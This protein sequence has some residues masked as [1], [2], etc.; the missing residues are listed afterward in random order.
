MHK[1]K[2]SQESAR[3]CGPP[4]EKLPKEQ[5][6]NEM[7]IEDNEVELEDTGW[8]KNGKE[9]ELFQKMHSQGQETCDLNIATR[10]TGSMTNNGEDQSADTGRQQDVLSEER[11]GENRTQPEEVSIEQ[12]DILDQRVKT[13]HF[14]ENEKPFMCKECGYRSAYRSGLSRHK[15]KHTGEID[16]NCDLCDYSV[17]NLH[18]LARHI[19]ANHTTGENPY[20]CKVCD[21]R[22]TSKSHMVSHIRAQS[23]VFKCD[24]CDYSAKRKEGL[25]RHIRARHTD[26]KP[27]MCEECGYKMADLSSLHTHRR[28]HTGHKPHKCDLCDYSAARKSYL[29][30]HMMVKHT[31]EKPYMCEECGYRTA[32]R[33]ALARHM[34]NHTGEKAHKCDLCDYSAAQKGTLDTHIMA[35]HTGEKP[36]MCGECGYRTAVRSSLAQHKKKHIVEKP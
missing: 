15:K 11:C 27:Y 32:H 16:H 10:H 5:T 34:K 13:K 9:D 17:T 31:G 26:E 4:S 3:A 2:F 30:N 12:K 28:K 14:D 23:R 35:K 20:T 22:T 33:N 36:Y 25:E 24:Q 19:L 21:F 29:D 6:A 1:S 7:H 18:I 8:Q